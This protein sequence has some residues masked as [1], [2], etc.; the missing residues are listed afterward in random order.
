[1]FSKTDEGDQAEASASLDFSTRPV[2]K[3]STPSL[4]SA[5][6][7]VV[8]NLTTDGELHIDGTV[9]GDIRCKQL[10]V[11]ETALLAGKITADEIE[12]RGRVAHPA[13]QHDPV[14]VRRVGHRAGQRH[15]PRAEAGRSARRRS[16]AGHPRAGMQDRHCLEA[17]PLMHFN[18]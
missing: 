14:P 3:D 10:T 2:S 17:K 8:G 7:E 15:S 11:G 5:N 13:G 9:A 6:L 4:V 16:G 12:V 1:M 18:G